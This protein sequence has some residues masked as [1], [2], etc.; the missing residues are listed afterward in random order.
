MLFVIL[1]CILLFAPVL[2]IAPTVQAVDIGLTEK[3][4]FKIRDYAPSDHWAYNASFKSLVVPVAA[5]LDED[6]YLEVIFSAGYRTDDANRWGIIICVDGNTG[7][8]QWNI[9]EENLGGH[10][11][12]EIAEID[13]DPYPEAIICGYNIMKCIHAENGTEIWNYTSAYRLDRPLIIANIDGTPYV[14]HEIDMAGG[15]SAPSIRK[16]YAINGIEVANV[17]SGQ[18]PCNGGLSAADINNDGKLEIIAV[19]TTALVMVYNVT[20]RI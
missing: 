5:N 9:S 14:Y 3:W 7:I 17:T 13:G 15:T 16:V 10:A 12:V 11:C 2:H 8:E 18:D 19:S 6:D 1:I 4:Y 20:M